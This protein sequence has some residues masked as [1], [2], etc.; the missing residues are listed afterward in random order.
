M[1]VDADTVMDVIAGSAWYTV[2]V[3]KVTDLDT[4]AARLADLVLSGVL[5]RDG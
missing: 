2:C 3:R 4:A 5:S 1:S